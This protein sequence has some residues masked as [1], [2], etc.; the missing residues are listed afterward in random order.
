MK[1]TLLL[2]TAFSLFLTAATTVS[3]DVEENW[4]KQCLKCHGA[5]GKGDTKMGQ[6]VGVKDYSDPKVQAEMTDESIVKVIVEGIKE[7]GKIKMKGYKEMFTEAEIKAFIGKV[8]SF[9]K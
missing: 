1:R 9:K 3:A 6:K 7:D 5:D 2:A 8:R 4:K